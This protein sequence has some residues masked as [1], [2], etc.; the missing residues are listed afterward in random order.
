[1]APLIGKRVTQIRRGTFERYY[2]CAHCGLSTTAR[3]QATGVGG[4]TSVLGVDDD[5]A[6]M[7]A[8]ESAEE[9]QRQHA[10]VSLGLVPCPR[11]G[12]RARAEVLYSAFKFF[13]AL[14]VLAILVAWPHGGS[15]SGRFG[16]RAVWIGMG[17]GTIIF[18]LIQI[19]HWLVAPRRVQFPDVR[20]EE[21]ASDRSTSVA[22]HRDAPPAPDVPPARVQSIGPPAAEPAP[23]KPHSLDSDSG[24]SILK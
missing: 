1:M 23:Q 4:G 9:D 7:T 18:L 19:R 5:G 14:V 10:N 24:P 11:C 17:V 21:A 8:Q 2:N 16:G 12:K 22:E 15:S 20:Q 13:G 3:V 6:A